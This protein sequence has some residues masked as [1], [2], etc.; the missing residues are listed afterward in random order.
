MYRIDATR[1]PESA[2]TVSAYQN[3]STNQIRIVVTNYNSSSVSRT[4]NITNAPTFTSLKPYITSAT[5]TIQAQTAVS[6]S[7]NS[8]TYAL[9]A[10]SVTT[11]AGTGTSAAPGTINATDCMVRG[12]SNDVVFPVLFCFGVVQHLV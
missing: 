12:D 7:G 5:Q 9:A 10:S 11:F 2:V 6:V 8:F 3:T 4:F 1:I